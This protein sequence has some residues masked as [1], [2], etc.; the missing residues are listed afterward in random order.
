MEW[1]KK[2]GSF[3]LDPVCDSGDDQITTENTELSVEPN[4][5]EN[6][7]KRYDAI[8]AHMGQKP[9]RIFYPCCEGDVTPSKAFPDS[10][11]TYVDMTR[12]I[13]E[14]LIAKN[15]DA[16]WGKVPSGREEIQSESDSSDAPNFIPDEEYDLLILLNPQIGVSGVV[17]WVRNGGYVLCNNYHN[18]AEE[19]N[20]R[21]EFTSIAVMPDS[22]SIEVDT[23]EL[24]DY[25]KLVASDEEYQ[26]RDP[27][28]YRAIQRFI[29]GKLRSALPRIFDVANAIPRFLE[30]AQGQHEMFDSV[31]IGNKTLPKPLRVKESSVDGLFLFQKS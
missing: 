30:K 18:T 25:F 26:R 10:M 7:A 15:Y 23:S 3:S 6:L 12:E 16:H 1:R 21:G 2:P 14:K 19:M 27:E 8:S 4:A 11:V 22:D 13:I 20:E 24:R 17:E 31:F 29:Y 28:S 9:G 5:S